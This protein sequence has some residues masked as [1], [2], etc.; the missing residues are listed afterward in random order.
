[1]TTNANGGGST[2]ESTPVKSNVINND[3]K[4]KFEDFK[5]E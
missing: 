4:R 3:K 5:R 1:M 2:D